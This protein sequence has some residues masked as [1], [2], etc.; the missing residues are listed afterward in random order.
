MRKIFV[1]SCLF[2]AMGYI[3]T[4]PAF[5]AR[6]R[7]AKGKPLP[8]YTQPQRQEYVEPLPPSGHEPP[9]SGEDTLN[10]I[11]IPNSTREPRE[12]PTKPAGVSVL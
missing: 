12:S 10:I 7:H 5:A 3:V 4:Q 11:N 2:L 9:S 6:E 8:I 1:F